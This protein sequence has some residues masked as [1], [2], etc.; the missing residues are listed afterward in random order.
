[1]KLEK[2]EEFDS[3][4]LPQFRQKHEGVPITGKHTCTSIKLASS[5]YTNFS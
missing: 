3:P 4:A 5:S 1:M 2:D